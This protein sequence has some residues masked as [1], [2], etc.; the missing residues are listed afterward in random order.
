M[1]VLKYLGYVAFFFVAF[2]L[3]LYW[4]FPWNAAKARALQ[5]AS[6]QTKTEISAETLEPNW[7]TGIIATGVKVLPKGRDEPIEIPELK[8]RAHILPLL[9]GGQGV[10][11]D[12]PVAQGNLH[13]DLVSKGGEVRVEGAAT[14]LELALVPGLKEATGIPLA[15]QI[16]LRAEPLT[17]NPKNPKNA[18]GTLALKGT[19]LEILAGGKVSNFPLPELAVGSFNWKVPIEKGKVMLN[20]LTL[21]GE[22]V[23]LSLDGTI[24]LTKRPELSILNL[25]VKFK[26]TQAFLTKEPLLKA[27]LQNIKRAQGGD[28]FYAYRITGPLS[29]PRAR[30]GA[31]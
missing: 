20:Q 27:L 19:D 7:F 4:T 12:I 30:M 2:L 22:N 31:R 9:S 1:K 11:V 8:A 25:T 17:F 13:A 21:K 28:G 10:T 24:A 23:E 16:T 26:P 15:G 14:D 6:A 3:S 29:R 5:M 18:E